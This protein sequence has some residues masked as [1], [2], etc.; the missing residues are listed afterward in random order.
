MSGYY[1]KSGWVRG[2]GV[3]VLFFMFLVTLIFYAGYKES[4]LTSKSALVGGG[5][6]LAFGLIYVL[7]RF[8]THLSREDEGRIDWVLE[9]A[10]NCRINAIEE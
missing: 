8:G 2:V 5:A 1:R 9:K 10:L 3:F 6:L 4:G 7:V